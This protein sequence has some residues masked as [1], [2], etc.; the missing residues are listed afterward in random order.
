MY[1]FGLVGGWVGGGQSCLFFL[2]KAHSVEMQQFSL[3]CSFGVKNVDR[4][5]SLDNES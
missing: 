5:K 3:T 1:I 2:Y 4:N